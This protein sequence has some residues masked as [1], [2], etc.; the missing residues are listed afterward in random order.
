MTPPQHR[1]D[2]GQK[3]LCFEP[4]DAKAK[5]IYF[6]KVNCSQCFQSKLPQILKHV[7]NIRSTVPHYEV[8]F[9]GWKC[10]WDREVPENL[11]LEN[12]EFNRTLKRRIDEIARHVNFI[13]FS[14]V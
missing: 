7:N 9:Q 12:T 14:I 5:V 3:L 1:F 13:M 11:L 4:D 2:I 10:K 6:A 8:H